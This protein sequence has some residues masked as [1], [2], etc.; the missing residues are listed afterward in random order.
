M[1]ERET[2]PGV[3][4]E[5]RDF[6]GGLTWARRLGGVEIGG[7][8]SWTVTFLQVRGNKF[9]GAVDLMTFFWWRGGSRGLKGRSKPQRQF[10]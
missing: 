8:D 6:Y 1:K 9:G 2:I 3:G 5:F 7:K 10:V 4:V